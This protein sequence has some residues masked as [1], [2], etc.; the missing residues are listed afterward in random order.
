M[1]AAVEGEKAK[2]SVIGYDVA[3]EPPRGAIHLKPRRA[4][5]QDGATAL[6]WISKIFQN[7]RIPAEASQ[8][9]S[10]EKGRLD[11]GVPIRQTGAEEVVLPKRRRDRG[12]A[13]ED[14]G[15][16]SHWVEPDVLRLFNR[17][18]TRWSCVLI[19]FL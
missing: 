15:L 16:K 3:F 2:K 19:S 14:V 10:D 17:C 9:D 6:D 18:L 12:A 11:C 1:D 7:I 4:Y 8:S 5:D 13:R